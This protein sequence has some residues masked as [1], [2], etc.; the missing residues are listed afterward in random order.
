MK[1]LAQLL[2][3]KLGLADSIGPV[4]EFTLSP[5]GIPLPPGECIPVD[6]YGP[7]RELTFSTLAVLSVG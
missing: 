5:V 2:P 6:L 1:E 7:C 3:K 4:M